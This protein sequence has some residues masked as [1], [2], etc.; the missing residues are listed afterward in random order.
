M[1]P[2]SDPIPGHYTY[3]SRNFDGSFN[4]E[5][6]SVL[7]LGETDRSFLVQILSPVGTHRKGDKM[8]VRKHNVRQKSTKPE[9]DYTNAPWNR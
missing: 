6:T 9:Y 3:K 4:Q 2:F 8:T 1:K 5:Y 7:I